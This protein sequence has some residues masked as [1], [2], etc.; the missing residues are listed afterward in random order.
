LQA[1]DWQVCL[2][3]MGNFARGWLAELPV[4]T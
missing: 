2:D 3:L 1:V 4:L